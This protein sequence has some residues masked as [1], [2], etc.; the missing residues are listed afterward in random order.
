MSGGIY[1]FVILSGI[2]GLAWSIYNYI[3]LKEIDLGPE[4]KD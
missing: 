3:K 1:V 4:G 2:A